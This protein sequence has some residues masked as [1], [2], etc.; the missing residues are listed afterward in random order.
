MNVSR[1]G[2]RSGRRTGQGKDTVALVYLIQITVRLYFNLLLK[3]WTSGRLG[4]TPLRTLDLHTVDALTRSRFLLCGLNG[5]RR[6]PRRTVGSCRASTGLT[7]RTRSVK[8]LHVTLGYE[9]SNTTSAFSAKVATLKQEIFN[10]IEFLQQKKIFCKNQDF[11]TKK[12][13]KLILITQNCV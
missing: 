6:F 11:M 9:H 1:R 8:L 2:G 4:D 10:L 12:K 7:T 5:S 13:K 3:V